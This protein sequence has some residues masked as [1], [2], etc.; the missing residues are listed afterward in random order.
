MIAQF[1]AMIATMQSTRT[2]M[3]S[4]RSTMAGILAQMD[5]MSDGAT[6]MGRAFDDAQNDDSFYIPP[7][8]FKNADFKRVM[9]V[10]LSPDGKTAR[11]LISQRGDPATPEGIARVNPIR[12]AAEEALKGTPLE[13]ARLL[14]HPA[15]RRWRKIRWTGRP[16]TSM[17]AGIA[18]LCLDLHHHADHD[19][20][21]WSR[22][23]SSWGPVAL[24][25]GR[26]VRACRCSIWQHILGIQLNWIVLAIALDHSSG[27]R[28]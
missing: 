24:S 14:P 23:W 11:L 12:T 17:I 7:A 22:P 26:G 8:V 15:A 28:F 4:M 5:E 21:A 6:A 18:A 19:S 13:N 25:L 27:G 3:L 9:D 2:M 16:M 1:P 20:G 10:F